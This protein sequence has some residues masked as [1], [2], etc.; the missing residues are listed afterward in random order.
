MGNDTTTAGWLTPTS[1]PPDNDQTLEK[2]LTQWIQGVSGLE[3][4]KVVPRWSATAPSPF[5]ANTNGCA[6]EVVSI[7]DEGYPAFENQTDDS[8]EMWRYQQIECM[9]SF[10]GPDSQSIGSQFRDGLNISQ[11]NAELNRLSLSLGE[12]TALISAVELGDD[13]AIRRYDMTIYLRRKLIRT[14]GVKSILS[15]SVSYFGE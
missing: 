6:F 15:A 7:N 2:K 5:P 10:F 8:A 9:T 11:N 1:A 3:E 13:P 14:Y 12:F 4:G